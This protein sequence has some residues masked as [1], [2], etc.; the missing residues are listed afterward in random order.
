[1]QIAS[2]KLSALLDNLGYEG[3]ANSF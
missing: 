3:P 1:M 2:S